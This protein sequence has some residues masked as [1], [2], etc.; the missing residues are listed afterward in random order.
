M[1]G[2]KML[3]SLAALVALS[4]PAGVAAQESAP[5]APEAEAAAIQQQLQSIQQRALQDPALQA[6]Q[7]EIGQEVV[8]TMGRVDST[9]NARAARAEAMAA[10][11]QA[12]QEAGDNARLNELNAEAQEIQQAFASARALAMQDPALQASIQAFQAEVVAKMTEIEPETTVLLAR[13][14]ELNGQ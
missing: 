3:A 2:R 9:F 8:A 11:I 13:L 5:A 14:N 4:L 12:A 7:A 1:T 10:D 6:R